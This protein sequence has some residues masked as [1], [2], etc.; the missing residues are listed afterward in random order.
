MDTS[1]GAQLAL[2]LLDGFESLTRQVID[3]LAERGH[4]AV[5]ATHEFALR[6]I[7]QG[8]DDAAALGRALGV[9]RQAA[10]KTIEALESLGYLRRLADPSDARRKRLVVT[11]R[12]YEMSRLGGAAYDA[13]RERWAASIGWARLEGVEAALHDLAGRDTFPT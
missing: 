1:R 2:L 9:S 4:P 13:L 3:E 7:D 11:D 8:A 5:T 10:A 6:A 12:G